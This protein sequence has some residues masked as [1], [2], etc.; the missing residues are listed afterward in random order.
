MSLALILETSEPPFRVFVPVSS[1]VEDKSSPALALTFCGVADGE[2]EQRR[3]GVGHQDREL[4][5][6]DRLL[7]PRGPSAC[8]G[9]GLWVHRS[10]RES[11]RGGWAAEPWGMRRASS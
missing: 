5:A 9:E 6:G 4:R 2:A 11:G 10:W 8:L 1:P 7:G 3:Q